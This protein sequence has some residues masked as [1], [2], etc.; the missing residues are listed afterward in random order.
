MQEVI[1]PP[2]TPLKKPNFFL[3]L[4]MVSSALVGAITCLGVS[5]ICWAAIHKS[6]VRIVLPSERAYSRETVVFDGP[7]KPWLSLA[8]ILL[9]AAFVTYIP[10]IYQIIRRK[11][12]SIDSA[13]LTSQL[14]AIGGLCFFAG[15]E[16]EYGGFLL[17]AL[18]MAYAG[19]GYLAYTR[20]ELVRAELYKD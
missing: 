18:L 4:G 11:K 5:V 7:G 19:N 16:I 17:G 13:K 10:R 8:S 15:A 14:M 20:W 1:P 12:Q 2:A 3:H 6:K 9:L